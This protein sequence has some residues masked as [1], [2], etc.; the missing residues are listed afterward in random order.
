MKLYSAKIPVIAREIIGQLTTDGDIE[1]NNREEAELDIQAVLKEYVRTDREV[2]ERA[3]DLLE[4]RNMAHEQF[5]KAKR[6]VAEEMGFGLGEEG[7]LWICNQVLETFMQSKFVDEV[8]ASDVDLRKKMK[9]IIRHHMM[10]DEELD[11]E[12]RKRI[13]NL[14]EGSATWEVEYAKVMEQIRQKRGLKE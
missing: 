10:V 7:V 12:V 5:G 9:T 2:T 6:T 8:F 13:L 3:K 1:I 11:G 4:R 14:E